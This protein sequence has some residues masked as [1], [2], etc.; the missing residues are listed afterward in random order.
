MKHKIQLIA[1][2]LDGTLFNSQSRISVYN[3]KILQKAVNSGITVIISTGRPYIGLPLEDLAEI[4]IHYAITANGAAIYHLPGKELLFE[5]CIDTKMSTT[6]LKELFQIELHLDAFINGDGYSQASTSELISRLYIPE[7]LREYIKTTRKRVP[8]LTAF[9]LENHYNISKITLN[10]AP[11]ADGSFPA[12][13]EAEAVLKR[14]PDIAYVSGGFNNL[15][16]TK[17]GISKAKG[18]AFLCNLLHIP[19]EDTMACGDSENDLDIV[20]AAGIGVAMSNAQQILI[21]AADFVSKSNDE[22]GVAYAV[23]ELCGV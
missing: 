12:R 4:G 16:L 2:D 7:P 21:D 23:E 14:Y 18:L 19:I 20:N 15:E 3:K 17:K 1:L 5:N 22:D 11:A 13:N 8:D 9:L 6:L 10:F